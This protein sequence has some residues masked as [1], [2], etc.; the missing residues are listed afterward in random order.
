MVNDLSACNAGDLGSIPGSR[1]SP[2]EGNGNALQSSCLE[3]PMDGGAWRAA[4]RGVTE[5]QTRLSDYTFVFSL[6]CQLQEATQGVYTACLRQISGKH[7]G[8]LRN[9][10]GFYQGHGSPEMN[11]P[12]FPSDTPVTRLTH[13]K[14]PSSKI[15]EIHRISQART[16]EWVAISSSRGLFL[17]QGSN[18]RLLHWQ[19][20]SLLLRQQG[21]PIRVYQTLF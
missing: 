7:I 6:Y 4:V 5:S 2:G 18:P 13:P 20:D 14:Q 11:M 10:S 16:L 8:S 15:G 1:R 9:R 3:N 12:R 19:V 17:S 21:S